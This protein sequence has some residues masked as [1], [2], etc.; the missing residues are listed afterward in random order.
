MAHRTSAPDLV[1]ERPDR[2]ERGRF[3]YERDR[4]RFS[5]LRERFEDDDDYVY[6][7]ERRMS[8]RPAPRERAPSVDRRSRAPYDDDETMI[9]ERRRVIYDDEQPRSI[10]R[11]RPSPESEVERR[12]VVIDKEIR[13]R[14]PSP[15]P[16]PGRLLRRQSSL[17]TFDR[18]PRGY[19]EREEYGPPARRQDHSVPPYAESHRPLPRSRALPPPR[20]YAEREYYD[21]IHVDDHYHD[22]PGRVHEREVIHTRLRSRSRESRTRSRRGRSRSSSRSSSSSSSGGTSLTARSEYPKKGKTRIPARLVSKRALIELGYPFVEEGNTIIVQKALGQ[23]NIDDLL[24][25]S[26]DYKKSMP[27]PLLS[28]PDKKVTFPGELEILAARSSAGDIIEERRTEIV[29]YHSTAP[30]PAVHYHHQ[31]PPAPAGNG[32]IIINAQPAPAPAPPVEVVKTTMIREQSPARSYT[33]TS[34]GTTTSYD[35]SLTSRGL[36]TVVVDARPRE[37]ALVEPPRDTW[38]YDENE[39]LRSEI[40][41]LERQLA[42]RE[43][44]K[45]RHSRHGSRGDLVRAERLSTGELVLYEEQIETIEEPARGGVRIEK[46]KRGRMSISVPRNR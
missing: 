33:T 43:R 3:E 30:P 26:D 6:E 25:L 37:V 17:D 19:Y 29:E 42:R 15:A 46:D 22:H 13:Y 27:A 9:R 23:K 38:R 7:R 39:D 8:S 16:R 4:D 21:E 14:S 36:P 2:F 11:R 31:H 32:P 5:E 24:K 18:R 45:S 44:S 12:S 35:T 20:V 41:H 1:R 40:R 10:L 34:Y 28:Y